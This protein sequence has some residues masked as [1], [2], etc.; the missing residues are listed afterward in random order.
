MRL[1][2][3]LWLRSIRPKTMLSNQLRGNKEKSASSAHLLRQTILPFISLCSFSS[4]RLMYNMP[5]ACSGWPI[6]FP[7][8]GRKQARRG[9]VMYRRRSYKRGGPAAK[10]QRN[11]KP[12]PTM[13]KKQKRKEEK[14]GRGNAWARKKR[15]KIIHVNHLCKGA[16]HHPSSVTAC[17]CRGRGICH[18][19]AVGSP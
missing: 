2:Q 9:L 16:V 12:S 15:G 11:Q 5:F 4:I 13:K 1:Q 6:A 7:E 19:L 17:L 14:S 3:R 8:G 18:A 10:P